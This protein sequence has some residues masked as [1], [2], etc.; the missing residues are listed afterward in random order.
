MN[1]EIFVNA[2]P[3]ADVS[4]CAPTKPV[5]K[6]RKKRQYR[7][8]YVLVKCRFSLDARRDKT[9]VDGLVRHHRRLF[10]DDKVPVEGIIIGDTVLY[11]P[12]NKLTPQPLRIVGERSLSKEAS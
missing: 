5:K 9:E 4:P 7:D 3:V 6:P 2:T 8:G 11:D 12:Q 10:V 1:F